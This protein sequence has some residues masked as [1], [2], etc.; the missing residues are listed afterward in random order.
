MEANASAR[1]FWEGAIA[2]FVGEAIRPR[3]VEKGGV[4]WTVFSF[5]SKGDG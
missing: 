1:H 3:F 5:E 4:R 2:L